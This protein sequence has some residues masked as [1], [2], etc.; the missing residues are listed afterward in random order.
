M[1]A[2][3]RTQTEA[4]FARLRTLIDALPEHKDD[5]APKLN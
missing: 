4:G 1:F 3:L 5:G 2:E